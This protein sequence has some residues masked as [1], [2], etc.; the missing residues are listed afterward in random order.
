MLDTTTQ[1]A[2]T[3]QIELL[4]QEIVSRLQNTEPG[5]CARVDFLTGTE[6]QAIWHYISKHH[7]TTGVAFHILTTNRTIAQADPLYITTDKAIEIRNRKLERLCLFIPS[8]IVDAAPSSIANSFAP[9]D[10]RTLYSLVLKQVRNK[11]TPELTGTVSSVFS[12]LRSMTGISEKQRL[13]F[14]LALL[15]QMQAGETA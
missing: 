2:H 4:A 10:G 3:I 5:H 11:L 8:D 12:R 1:T 7:L 14:T 9:I 13:D 15:V 6:A